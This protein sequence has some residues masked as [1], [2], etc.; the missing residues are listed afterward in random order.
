MERM[1][2]KRP[3]EEKA[4]HHRLVLFPCPCQGHLAPMLQLATLLHSRGFSITIVHSR[5]N[6]PHPSH[7]PDFMFEPISDGLSSLINPSFTLADDLVYAL[8][9]LNLNCETPFEDCL[10]R[11]LSQQAT[12]NSEPILCI[13]GD[14]IMHFTKGVAH[15]FGLPHIAL[16]TSSVTSLL[17]M[18][19]FL[20]HPNQG[21]RFSLIS[22]VQSDAFRSE[23]EA[24][25]AKDIPDIETGNPDDLYELVYN[26]ITKMK[27]SSGLIWN[28]WE[29]LE[30]ASLVKLREAFLQVPIFPVGPLHKQS[31]GSAIS[32]W[33]QDPSCMSWLDK[34]APKSVIY[35]S[36]GSLAKIKQEDLVEM[37]WGLANSKQPFLW[38]IRPGSVLH[39]SS[40]IELPG[41]FTEETKDRGRILDWA[42][43]QQLLAHPAIGGFWSHCGWNSFLEALCEG[44]PLLCSPSF[45]DQKITARYAS[46]VWRV[47]IQFENGLERSEIEKAIRRLML[48]K[49]GEELKQR[50]DSMKKSADLCLSEGGSS[51]EHLNKLVGFILSL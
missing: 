36:F 46:H 7:Y 24:V 51:Y 34:Q 39:D 14:A 10:V 19:E 47:G 48:E 22:G 16:R 6:S 4:G 40:Q 13:I 30:E 25:R 44:V 5:F 43:Q 29:E 23:V 1:G 20:L 31:S 32:L 37:A 18:I 41:E 12:S 26:M 33:K 15:K 2:D 28:T 38:V 8:K 21:K 17:A 27:S 11:L 50:I 45:T 42:P 3:R 49:E 35:V 9:L